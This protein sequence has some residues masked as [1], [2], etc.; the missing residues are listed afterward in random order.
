M[1]SSVVVVVVVVVVVLSLLY[2]TL[3]ILYTMNISNKLSEFEFEIYGSYRVNS[4]ADT[5][6]VIGGWGGMGGA[7]A[8]VNTGM[9]FARYTYQ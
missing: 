3:S 1:Q 8:V 6:P 4:H 7:D 9:N 5:L 2:A